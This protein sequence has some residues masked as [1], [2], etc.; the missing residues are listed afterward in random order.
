MSAIGTG[1]ETGFSVGAA[2]GD[3]GEVERGGE[4][5]DSGDEEG[6]GGGGGVLV[7]MMAG[8]VFGEVAGEEG[9]RVCQGCA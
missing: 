1:G 6:A 9:A 7:A 2:D 8:M 5:D 3:A 4:E